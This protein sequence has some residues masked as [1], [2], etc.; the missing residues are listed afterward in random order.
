MVKRLQVV[1]CGDR[2]AYSAAVVAGQ[3]QGLGVSGAVLKAGF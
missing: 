3:A 2:G 1:W